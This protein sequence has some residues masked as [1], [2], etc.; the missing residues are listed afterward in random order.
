MLHPERVP[1]RTPQTT[2]HAALHDGEDYELLV[3]VRPDRIAELR[4][5]WPFADVP[6]TPLGEFVATPPPGVYDANGQ[7][8]DDAGDAGYDHLARRGDLKLVT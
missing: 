5:A 7:R 4:A 3:A 6:L 8:L 1:L 2:R